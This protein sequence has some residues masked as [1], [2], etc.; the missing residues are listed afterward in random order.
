MPIYEI[1]PEYPSL[2]VETSI[3]GSLTPEVRQGG[4]AHASTTIT[5]ALSPTLAINPT[6]NVATTIVATCNGF[7][8]PN[9]DLFGEAEVATTIT[10]NLTSQLRISAQLQV[11]TTIEATLTPS[12]SRAERFEERFI[13]D[14]LLPRESGIYDARLTVDGEVLSIKSYSFKRGKDTI[15]HELAI[16]LSNPED[17]SLIT[18]NSQITFE[19][20]V[21][22][23]YKTILSSGYANESSWDIRYEGDTFT[24]VGLTSTQ[25]RL[26]RT[27]ATNLVLYDPNLVDVDESDFRVIYDDYGR[28]FETE[29]LAIPNMTMADIFDEIFVERCGFTSWRSNL[30]TETW[31]ISRIDFNAGEAYLAPLKGRVGMYEPALEEIGNTLWIRGTGV[32][33]P[34]GEPTPETITVS[35]STRPR[36]VTNHRRIDVIEMIY[37]LW[38]YEY[39]YTS[40]RT[41]NSSF[42]TNNDGEH[43]IT[44]ITRTIQEYY[45]ESQPT[46]PVHEEPLFIQTVD[47][48]GDG[49]ILEN[50][51]ERFYYKGTNRIGRRKTMQV[52][53][54]TSIAPYTPVLQSAIWESED[55]Y[56]KAHPFRPSQIYLQWRNMWSYGLVADDYA[57]P[58]ADG[59]P[60]RESLIDSH[61]KANFNSSTIIT[62]GPIKSED[63]V[64]SVINKDAVEIRVL[65]RD[66]CANICERSW[67]EQR[68]GDIGKSALVNDQ[69]QLYIFDQENAERTF[70]F[71]ETVNIGELNP[72][73]GKKLCRQI[74]N[75]RKLYPKSLSD[76][77]NGLDLNLMEGSTRRINDRD[78]NSLGIYEITAVTFRG[79]NNGH[80]TDF[81]GVQSA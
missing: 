80:F 3:V 41:E 55:Y 36:V 50:S 19:L 69:R 61:R 45:R 71:K 44:T 39:D 23:T 15:R 16:E 12:L 68:V 75:R 8:P 29:I 18:R 40:T 14:R 31:R 48:R 81:E 53:V 46:L 65:K 4:T 56:W 67:T 13:I 64:T 59:T 76:S 25:Q 78:G 28:A 32:P 2:L 20:G 34:S 79:D 30:P 60:F 66:H 57:N 70:D 77:L 38:T 43:I 49:W 54:P 21:D 33:Y 7:V 11:S 72:I 22:G 58:R 27:P 17:G 63:E 37:N 35:E 6:L 1:E 9:P 42:S 10:A 47:L 5:A 62:S 51:I 74:L 26:N 73:E 52:P 24:F